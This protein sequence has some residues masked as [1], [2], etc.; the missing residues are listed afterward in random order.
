MDWRVTLPKRV[1][2]PTWGPPPPPKKALKRETSRTSLVTRF[3]EEMFVFL[4]S[5][6]FFTAAHFHL[7]GS[8][9]FSFS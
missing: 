5:L 9:L 1:T 8:W 2:S 7:G 6:C 4:G 3:M